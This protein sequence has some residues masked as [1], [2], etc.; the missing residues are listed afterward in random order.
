MGIRFDILLT[1]AAFPTA[2]ISGNAIGRGYTGGNDNVDLTVCNAATANVATNATRLN[3]ARIGSAGGTEA[4]VIADDNAGT[5]PVDTTGGNCPIT[6]V[7]TLPPAVAPL[8]AAAGGVAAAKPA[9]AAALRQSDLHAT[10]TAAI[11]RLRKA[12]TLTTQQVTALR[13]LSFQVADLAGQTLGLAG[14]GNK[15]VKIDTDAAGHGWY[16][17]ATPADDKEF[18]ARTSATR[19]YARPAAAPAGRMNLLTA[20]MHELG[21][22]LSVGHAAGRDGLML[23]TLAAG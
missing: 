12:G 9:P 2:N 11:L 3:L 22:V 6:L 7:N 10:R 15:V 13:A 18:A 5:P 8:L 23:D 4:A 21:H 20:V 14:G 16:V 17:D 1:R 19:L